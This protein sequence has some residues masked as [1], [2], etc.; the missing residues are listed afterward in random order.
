MTTSALFDWLRKSQ[1]RRRV[2]LILFVPWIVLI[3]LFHVLG[4]ARDIAYE[5][6]SEMRMDWWNKP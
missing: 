4:A 2:T 5:M 3:Y 1:R 6:W